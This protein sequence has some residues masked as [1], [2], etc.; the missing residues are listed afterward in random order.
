MSSESPKR[1]LFDQ[2]ARIGQALAQG[3]RL[4]ILELCA[5][6]EP[7]VETVAERVG[8]SV[9]NASQH[10]IQLRR[11]G[12]VRSRRDGR[13]VRYRVADPAVVD[14]LSS[15]RH[16]A[17]RTLAEVREVVGGYFRERDAMEAVSREELAARL[18]DGLVTVLDVRPQDEFA[19]GHLPHAA[20]IPLRDL[21]RRLAELPKD[22]EI[23]AYCRGA[24]CVLSFEA[25]A[26]LR[27]HGYVAR[28]LEDG[29]PE[30]KCDGLP[31]EGGPAG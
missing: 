3:R 17:E 25:V 23:V 15:L 9:A 16:V 22:R 30:W 7:S 1:L 29:F 24:Y 20:N 21:E 18:R 26:M 19:S 5:Q 31:V 13:H 14:L 27:R 4:E 28:R 6:G 11:A 8:L 10:L 12:L 2:L